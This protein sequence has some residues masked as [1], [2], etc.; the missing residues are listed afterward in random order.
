MILVLFGFFVGFLWVFC[1]SVF[2]KPKQGLSKRPLREDLF[3][4][5]IQ[6]SGTLGVLFPKTPGAQLDTQRGFLGFNEGVNPTANHLQV[7]E[8]L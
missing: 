2:L 6:V 7:V 1:F 4:W 3:T 5:Q 8:S